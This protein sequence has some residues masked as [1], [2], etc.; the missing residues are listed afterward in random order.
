MKYTV[1]QNSLLQYFSF[2]IILPVTEN[3]KTATSHHITFLFHAWW[4]FSSFLYHWANGKGNLNV[5]KTFTNQNRV[6]TYW[7]NL[8][9]EIYPRKY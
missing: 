7:H 1:D 8:D 5:D 2:E 4:G 6:L 9:K 3:L